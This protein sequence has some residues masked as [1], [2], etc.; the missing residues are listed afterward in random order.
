MK[1]I[2]SVSG[3]QHCLPPDAGRAGPQSEG[4]ES[5]IPETLSMDLPECTERCI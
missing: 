3:A 2:D 1:S 4:G 5:T